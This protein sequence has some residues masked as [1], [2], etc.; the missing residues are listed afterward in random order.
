MKALAKKSNIRETYRRGLSAPEAQV[1]KNKVKEPYH[2]ISIL[3][4][5]VKKPKRSISHRNGMFAT[6]AQENEHKEAAMH[7]CMQRLYK[8][9]RPS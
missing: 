2:R 6:K 5:P 9:A 7:I 8:I 4:A 3:E 1:K